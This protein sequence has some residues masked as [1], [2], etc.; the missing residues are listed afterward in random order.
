MAQPNEP[1]SII[2]SVKGLHLNPSTFGGNA[3]E[4][5]LTIADNV[6][7]DRPSIV[8]TRRG[9][10]NNYLQ[11][12]ISQPLSFHQYNNAL[13]V[14]TTDSLGTYKL[15]TDI[16]GDGTFTEYSGDYPPPAPTEAGSRVR[17]VETN[18]NFYCL[19]D[20]GTYRLDALSGT[21]RLAGCPPGQSGGGVNVAATSGFLPASTYVAYR[22]VFGYRDANSNLILGAPSGRIVVKNASTTD[23]RNVILYF[24]VPP[25]I[26]SA[27]SNFIFQV[28]RSAPTA[29]LTYQPNDEMYLVYEEVCT[30]SSTITITDVT[31]ITLVGAALYTNQGQEG[32]LNS[33]YRPPWARDICLFKQYA[34]FANTRTA[35]SANMTL[36]SAGAL[37]GSGALIPGDTI[38]FTPIENPANAFTLTAD[39]ATTNP[40]LGLFQVE[41]T[42]DAAGNIQQTAQNICYVAN[43]YAT[44]TFIRATYTSNFNELP[45]KMSFERTSLIN[46]KFTITVSRASAIE[47]P[48]PISA[49]ND[50][51][52]NRV[53]FSKFNQ[54]DSVPL[55]NYVD[56]G[57]ANQPINR[58]LPLRDGVMVMKQ[59][60][61]FRI[62]NA[63]P[64]FTI[65]PV[66]YNL[67]ILADNTAAEL[68]NRIYFLS[69]QG[70]VALGDSDAEIKSFILDRTIIENTSPDIY[71]NLREVAW[72]LAYQSDRKYILSLPTSGADTIAT[73]Q[74]VYNNVTE[75]WTRWTIPTNC[76]LVLKRDAKLYLGVTPGNVAGSAPNNI[77]QERKSFTD[78]D[79][80]D[81][82]YN[83][84]YLSLAF[85]SYYTD[86]PW[87]SY[88]PSI[89][90]GNVEGAN[91]VAIA[92]DLYTTPNTNV[93]FSNPQDLVGTWL[94]QETT[95]L[96]IQLTE[97]I[98]PDM[99]P[100]WPPG[101]QPIPGMY[102][103]TVYNGQ[104]DET[105][106]TLQTP[107]FSEIQT[108]QIDA[109]NPG[110]NKQY[111]E[112]IY[113][114]SN[115]DFT[116]IESRISSNTISS[117]IVDY[118][119]P[120]FSG[121]WGIDTWG[122]TPWGGSSVGQGKIRRY[123]Q[124][125]MQ[126]CG[127]L[128]V[129]L[130]NAEPY[131]AFGFSGLEL[132]FR[133]TS[134]R[135]P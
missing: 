26:T 64:P 57:S 67:R 82:I 25:E 131:S 41:N 24:Q 13:I 10:D 59:D 46:S 30:S 47:Q 65:T 116:K 129:N 110:M 132:Y 54:P 21:P 61:V 28:Y 117:P 15:I 70:I 34:F 52:V 8:A 102:K 76:G 3:P 16:N 29:D 45:G 23:S 89:W 72:G 75:A 11:T 85:T 105:L 37:S 36:I 112:I 103:I 33:N 92:W 135:Q 50:A 95:D 31:P 86:N 99:E 107:V 93:P 53:Y 27:P 42:T 127:W 81:S 84:D 2:L 118:L 108:I 96:K 88:N 39:A 97:Y 49:V 69:D 38:T 134:T 48:L 55:I 20:N 18:K 115:Q 68:G 5:A 101:F 130:R 120:S 119:T 109:A 7:I 32:I 35:F 14:N 79:Y 77:L 74:Y 17:S 22:I 1:T 83:V 12:S 43:G 122:S 121:G 113:V 106:L 123:I 66:D 51:R 124:Q 78:S 128:Y 133:K 94:Y 60:G 9:F 111:N 40:A 56:V 62:S 63:A 100:V 104:I 125:P 58:I 87:T 4:G 73:Q 71:P 98:A 80:V 90:G 19:T 6:V 44:N 126:R 114:F 91:Y